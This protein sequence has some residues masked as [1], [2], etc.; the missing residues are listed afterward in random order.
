MSRTPAKPRRVGGLIGGIGVLA[1]ALIILRPAAGH[2]E[3]SRPVEGPKLICFKYSTFALAAG[4]RVTDMAR[5]PEAVQITIMGP[6]GAYNIGE[7]EIIG[8]QRATPK[9]IYANGPTK[10]FQLRS[11]S[12]LY[13]VFGPTSFSDGAD[14]LVDVLSGRVLRSG[15]YAAEVYRRI[16]VRDPAS[17]R[18]EATFSYSFGDFLGAPQDP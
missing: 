2:A 8:A 9:P 3:L 10:V 14:V 18:C 6:R 12:W 5:S 15:A 13:G 17:A 16:E 1:Q 7:S 4:E 11:K